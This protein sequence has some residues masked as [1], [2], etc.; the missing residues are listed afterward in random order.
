MSLKLLHELNAGAT[1]V[2]SRWLANRKRAP[3]IAWYPSAGQDFRDLLHLNPRFAKPITGETQAPELFLHTDYLAL[4]LPLFIEGGTLYKDHRTRITITEQEELSSLQLPLDPEIVH[5]PAGNTWTG[6]VF[7]L[8]IEVRSSELGT[9]TAPMLYVCAENAAF[10]ALK[11]LPSRARVTH[12]V[13]VRYGCGY[14]GGS[15][16]G[17][18]LLNVLRR[19]HCKCFLTDFHLHRSSGD[20]RV[21]QL[22][23]SLAGPERT[24]CLKEIRVTPG[25]RWSNHGDVSWN[26]VDHTSL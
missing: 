23:P 2:F 9:F 12:V 17:V 16:S 14:G 21:Y 8:N 6:R 19:V 10:C 22:F 11:M 18:W 24:D 15:S 3:R 1:G 4:G 26:L 20:E 25:S 5:H 13:H 7:F